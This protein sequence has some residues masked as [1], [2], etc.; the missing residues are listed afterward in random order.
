MLCLSG[1]EL[2]SRWLPLVRD[3]EP[4]RLLESPRSLSVYILI[5]IACKC[6]C[7]FKLRKPRRTLNFYNGPH[8]EA[9]P[10][11]DTFLRL[12]II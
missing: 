8:V 6:L 11:R 5:S 12:N 3:I 4:I 9:L 7:F 10:G 2:Y 1:F